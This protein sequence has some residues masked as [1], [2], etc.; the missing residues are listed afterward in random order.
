MDN[1][2][3]GPWGSFVAKAD[4][5]M[6]KTEEHALQGINPGGYY[7]AIWCRDASYI[8]RDWTLSGNTEAALQQLYLIWSHQI[9]PGREKLV[10][11]RGSPEM[12]FLSE[13]AKEDKQKEFEGALPT[14]IYQAGFSEVYGQNPDIDSTA[15]MLSTTAWILNKSLKRKLPSGRRLS[16][17]S[18]MASEHSSDYVSG[19]L[20]KLGITDPARAIDFL[21]PRMLRAVDYLAKRDIDNDGLLEQNHNEDWMDTVLRAGKIVYSQACWILALKNLLNLLLAVDKQKESDRINRMAYSAVQAVEKKLWSEEDGAYIDIQETHHIG[22]PYRTLTQDVSLYLVA[23]SE[24]SARD[25]L[26]NGEQNFSGAEKTGDENLQRANRALDAIR[27]RVWKEKWPLVTEVELKSTGPWY[28]KPYQYH[29]HTFWPWTTGIEMLARSRFD[30]VEECNLLLSTLTSESNLHMRTF[31]EWIN[32]I[33]DQGKGAFPFRTGI[34]AVRI[35]VVDI[36]SNI[37]RRLS[38][39]A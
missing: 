14:T 17:V 35:S 37:R 24:N 13:E 18:T 26:T 9:E 20:L 4:I 11:G 29:N 2:P 28:L 5:F 15:L 12:K 34:S 16:E 23:I 3:P 21:I 22:G 32:P 1:I 10:Y 6:T 36:L 30:R 27:S 7:Q 39:K 25:S 33:T 31:Y 8:L 38:A 19:L